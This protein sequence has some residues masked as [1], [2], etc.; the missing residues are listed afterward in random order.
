MTPDAEQTLTATATTIAQ[1]YFTTPEV[2]QIRGSLRWQGRTARTVAQV[3]DARGR[4][5]KITAR[6]IGKLLGHLRQ[7]LFPD[8]SQGVLELSVRRDHSWSFS[9]ASENPR[10]VLVREL[11]P[12]P[13]PGEVPGP[14]AEQLARLR[15]LWLAGA[16]SFTVEPPA[17]AA[18]LDRLAATIGYPVPPELEALLSLINGAQV[19]FADI[20][21]DAGDLTITDNWSLLSTTEIARQWKAA[22]NYHRIDPAVD[23]GAPDV[24]QPRMTHPGW[25]PFAVD[26]G[27]NYLAVDTVPGPGGPQPDRLSGRAAPAHDHR[28]GVHPGRTRREARPGGHRRP[29]RHPAAQGEQRHDGTRRG[30]ERGEPVEDAF[31]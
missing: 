15:Q 19:N 5:L 10:R 21:E 18:E 22:C 23:L 16:D 31:C 29:G 25:V 8:H 27:G 20:D 1:E 17:D 26:G 9:T 3:L 28:T 11:T 12:T 4:L 2:D 30:L 14:G 6:S 7:T 13:A 24:T